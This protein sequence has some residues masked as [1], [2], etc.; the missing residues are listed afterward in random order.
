[1]NDLGLFSH[2]YFWKAR[3]VPL[4]EDYPPPPQIKLKKK[5]FLDKAK[6]K[7]YRRVIER[8]FYSS[9]FTGKKLRHLSDLLRVSQE[10]WVELGIEY[11]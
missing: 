3:D 5:I 11:R 9:H 6:K 8:E 1:M 4:P 2:D 7:G 10:A